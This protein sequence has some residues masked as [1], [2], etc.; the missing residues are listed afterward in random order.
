[1]PLKNTKLYTYSIK[2]L[3]TEMMRDPSNYH[4]EYSPDGSY[5]LFQFVRFNV[6]S[7]LKSSVEYVYSFVFFEYLLDPKNGSCELTIIELQK[8]SVNVFDWFRISVRCLFKEWPIQPFSMAIT[9][10]TC[11]VFMFINTNFA[12]ACN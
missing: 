8:Q 3:R 12:R 10:S 9:F 6:I 4:R 2:F 1:M 7:V 11:F 5:S